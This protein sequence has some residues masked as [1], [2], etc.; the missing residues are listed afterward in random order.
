MERLRTRFDLEEWEP[1]LFGLVEKVL[2]TSDVDLLL[3]DA[4]IE[5][6]T[7]EFSASTD[8]PIFE[9]PA[10]ERWKILAFNCVRNDGDRTIDRWKIG[11]GTTSM[12]VTTFAAAAYF[13]SDVLA[14]PLILD[15]GWQLIVRTSSAGS[16]DGD[17]NSFAYVLKEDAY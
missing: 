10:G 14:E 4:A 5:S 1:E 6:D 8:Y 17:Y 3:Q 11:D 7:R 2:L 9:V 16:T 15:E 12:I 13:Y